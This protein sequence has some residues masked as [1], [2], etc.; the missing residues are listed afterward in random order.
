[1]V[2]P[3]SFASSVDERSVAM[4]RPASMRWLTSESRFA[5]GSSLSGASLSSLMA[6]RMLWR[7]WVD[8]RVGVG[9][10]MLV[11]A[12]SASGVGDEAR[13]TDGEVVAIDM[14]CARASRCL[15][16]SSIA[17]MSRQGGTP[18]VRSISS[19]GFCGDGYTALHAP[20][21]SCNDLARLV[22]VS[23]SHAKMSSSSLSARLNL[24]AAKPCRG[25]PSSPPA[26][27]ADPAAAA[28]WRCR[29]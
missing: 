21:D 25:S 20:K 10:T 14:R 29:S 28:G 9:S 7:E 11:G 26:A 15:T 18:D 17:A 16:F 3:A 22:R 4:G 12:E 6:V 24:Q 23:Y 13:Q 5:L 1:M 2:M 19:L 8:R 27:P